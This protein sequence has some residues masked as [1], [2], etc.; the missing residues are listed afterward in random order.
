[1]EKRSH[2]S[3]RQKGKRRAGVH[4]CVSPAVMRQV[5]AC[6]QLGLEE[7]SKSQEEMG[8]S[9]QTAWLKE[10]IPSASLLDTQAAC[11]NSAQTSAPRYGCVLA[12]R[13]SVM[14]L[15]WVGILL[16]HPPGEH[17]SA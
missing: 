15:T 14:S 7:Q 9:E 6:R 10:V 16:G 8:R 1:M 3:I 13:P 17:G 5:A 4:V 12:L 11:C 2:Q